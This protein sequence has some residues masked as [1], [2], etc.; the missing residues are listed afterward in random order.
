[1]NKLLLA[2]N[3]FSGIDIEALL[4]RQQELNREIESL[5][6]KLAASSERNE[7]LETKI[8]SLEEQIAELNRVSEGLRADLEKR[9]LDIVALQDTNAMLNTAKQ[10]WNLSR[11]LWRAKRRTCRSVSAKL[12]QTARHWMPPMRNSK[13]LM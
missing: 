3:K 9:S 8:Q 6:Q 1:M 4:A 2:L 10:N 13:A 7:E 5:K 11:L 12:K